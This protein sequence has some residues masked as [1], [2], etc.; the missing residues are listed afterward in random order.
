MNVKI[1]L[2]DSSGNALF[3]DMSSITSISVN[4]ERREEC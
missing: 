4:G 2:I 3:V 1:K